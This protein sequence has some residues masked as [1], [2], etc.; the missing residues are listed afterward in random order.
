MCFNAGKKLGKSH[1]APLGALYL[2]YTKSLGSRLGL[3]HVATIVA[4]CE[5]LF[6]LEGCAGKTH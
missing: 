5:I 1:A 2:V 6:D 4:S 3:Q